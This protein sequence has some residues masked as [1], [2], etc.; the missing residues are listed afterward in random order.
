[1]TTES[2]R[3]ASSVEFLG[4]G[5]QGVYCLLGVRGLQFQSEIDE[6]REAMVAYLRPADFCL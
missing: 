2:I 4:L 1:M 6:D 5:D 3:E